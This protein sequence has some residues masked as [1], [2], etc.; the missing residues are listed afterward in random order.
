M[1]GIGDRQ[2][3]LLIS[4]QR[5]EGNQVRFLVQDV[6]IGFGAGDAERL[7]EAFYSTKNDGMGIGLSVSQSII[8]AHK[9]RLW[10]TPN[11]GPGATVCFSVPGYAGNEAYPSNVAHVDVNPAQNSAR[12]S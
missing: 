9:G 1:T 5:D 6:G 8:D 7:F 10:A 12:T 3:R 11:N 2:R 4:T